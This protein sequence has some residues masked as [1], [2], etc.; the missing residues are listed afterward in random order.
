MLH[1]TIKSGDSKDTSRMLQNI[2]APLVRSAAAIIG[3]VLKLATFMY[4]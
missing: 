3:A 2:E 1:R 4:G